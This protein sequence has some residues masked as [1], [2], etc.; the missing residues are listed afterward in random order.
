MDILRI[1]EAA[2]AKAE[3]EREIEPKIERETTRKPRTDI[4]RWTNKTVQDRKTLV[5][6]QGCGKLVKLRIVSPTDLFT[7]LL[8]ID[9]ETVIN[10]TYD[11][12]TETLAAYQE[13]STFYLHLED[14]AFKESLLVDVQ[15]TTPTT[16]SLLYAEVEVET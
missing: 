1:E 12:L 5:N 16:F 4:Y 13:D 11:D 3:A 7:L 9:G 8:G 14:K 10:D 2:R 6:I 15:V